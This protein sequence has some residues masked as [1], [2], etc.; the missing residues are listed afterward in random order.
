VL[1]IKTLKRA[2]TQNNVNKKTLLENNF[3]L[4][5]SYGGEEV[6]LKNIR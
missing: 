1:V 4:I 3:N 5:L 6:E 2:K